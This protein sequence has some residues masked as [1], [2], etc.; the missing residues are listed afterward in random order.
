MDLVDHFGDGSGLVQALGDLLRTDGLQDLLAG[1]DDAGEE[2]KVESWLGNGPNEPT[3][4]GGV[5]RALGRTRTTAI[6]ERLGVT[7]ELAAAGLAR[8]I[9]IA[10]DALT[11]GGRRPTGPV[12]SLVPARAAGGPMTRARRLSSV[13]LIIAIS[14]AG[15]GS[16]PARE[17]DTVRPANHGA[18]GTVLSGRDLH[19]H[20]GTLLA[21][22]YTR[23]SGMMVD[24]AQQPCPRVQLRG[25]KSLIGST[26][27][28]VYVDGRYEGGV[29]VLRTIPVGVVAEVRYLRPVAANHDLGRFHAGGAISVRTRN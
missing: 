9:P 26:D 5:E 25:R 8:I 16:G 10:V 17:V 11:P 2:S 27:P 1:F 12:G 20:G 4:V 7:P 19:E 22:L 23:V 24:F 28:V 14:T 15:C 29:D 3:E 18:T 13:V 6:G 21:F